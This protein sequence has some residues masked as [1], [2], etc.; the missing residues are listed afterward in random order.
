MYVCA[1]GEQSVL[2][3]TVTTMFYLVVVAFV[4]QGPPLFYGHQ[5]VSVLD[6]YTTILCLL[7]WFDVVGVVIQRPKY[8]PIQ[9]YSILLFSLTIMLF[10]DNNYKYCNWNCIWFPPIRSGYYFTFPKINLI[11]RF[12]KF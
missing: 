8:L 1:Q 9:L 5:S 4:K 10:N 12:T 3:F 11:N 6:Y 7:T 2:I